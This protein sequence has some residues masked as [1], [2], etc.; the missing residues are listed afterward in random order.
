[1]KLPRRRFLHLAVG[2]AGLPAVSRVVSIT[3]DEMKYGFEVLAGG[4]ILEMVVLQTA[5]THR[6]IERDRLSRTF[7]R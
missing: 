5:P 1:M 7:P 6:S 3:A 4:P 2:A